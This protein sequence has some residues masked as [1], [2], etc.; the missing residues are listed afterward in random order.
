MNSFRDVFLIK[1]SLISKFYC[2][3]NTNN[4][5]R[6]EELYL[7]MEWMTEDFICPYLLANK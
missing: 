2:L 3:Q 7:H 4:M 1:S 6:H 5:A